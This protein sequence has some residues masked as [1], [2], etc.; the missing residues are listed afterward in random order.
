MAAV[1]DAAATTAIQEGTMIRPATVATARPSGMEDLF[2]QLD[3]AGD[4][5]RIASAGRMTQVR[6][7]GMPKSIDTWLA[8]YKWKP[9]PSHSE[10]KD[11][12]GSSFRSGFIT[13]NK[14]I[15]DDVGER[16]TPWKPEILDGWAAVKATQSR[17][18]KRPK[19][20]AP[21]R[22]PIHSNPL[23][24]PPDSLCVKGHQE[25]LEKHAV[26]ADRKIYSVY[27]ARKNMDRA[28]AKAEERNVQRA[29]ARD[30]LTRG[31]L[32]MP[33]FSEG[34]K[35]S[36]AKVKRVVH[37]VGAFAEGSDFKAQ[38]EANEKRQEEEMIQR[39]K[40]APALQLRPP[41][42]QGRVKHV[43]DWRS[44]NRHLRHLR[45]STP[46]VEDDGMRELKAMQK[47]SRGSMGSTRGSMSGTL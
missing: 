1:E 11:M 14:H 45:S 3:A 13:Y 31:Q 29:I 23:P 34:V 37:A 27:Y 4:A 8:D 12:M 47:A 24:E 30:M 9:K 25:W 41:T 26:E 16:F 43:V 32:D 44:N 20:T 15:G 28:M 40:S 6:G 38:Q 33:D 10:V 22:F 17:D 5:R 46:W 2:K 21:A 18:A 7:G 19:G 42:P 39:A 35:Q 36:L